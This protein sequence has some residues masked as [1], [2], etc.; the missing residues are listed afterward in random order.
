MRA[1]RPLFW[2]LFAALSGCTSLSIGENDFACPGRPTGVRCLS[3]SEVYRATE[4]T[5]R[6]GATA[7]DPLGEDPRTADNK[8]RAEK[9]AIADETQ[10][11]SGAQ[12]EARGKALSHT[13]VP[14][15][16]KPIPVRTPAQVMRVWIVP[17]EDVQG[18]LHAGGYH[19]TEIEARRWSLGER[20]AP[21]PVRLFSIQPTP[22]STNGA[23]K[24]P[25]AEDARPGKPKRKPTS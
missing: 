24:T 9:V 10:T 17:W 20:I 22:V 25:G 16:E 12:R 8:T 6:V 1:I 5:D 18:V 4:Q 2:L 15:G 23:K 14:L 21:E 3:A 11:P 19:F 13:I 7:T